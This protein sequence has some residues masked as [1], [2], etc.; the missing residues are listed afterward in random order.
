MVRSEHRPQYDKTL[1]FFFQ[2]AMI[3]SMKC[4]SYMLSIGQPIPEVEVLARRFY[5]EAVARKQE[6]ALCM[7][8]PFLQY[9]YIMMGISDDKMLLESDNNIEKETKPRRKPEQQDDVSIGYLHFL[10]MLPAYLFHDY[11]KAA[12]HA[13]QMDIILNPAYLQPGIAT[14]LVCQALAFLGIVEIATDAPKG[15]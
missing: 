6:T 4:L 7:M 5:Q 3:A 14:R 13:D 12:E 1:T 15:D 8:R 11:E 10:K 2:F 9:I